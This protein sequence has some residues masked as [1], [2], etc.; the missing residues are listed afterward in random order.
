MNRRTLFSRLPSWVLRLLAPGYSTCLACGVPWRF[1]REHSTPYAHG[2][3]T[4]SGMFPLCEPCWASMK[5]D[6]R[7]PYYAAL[8]AKWD[9]PPDWESVESAVRAGL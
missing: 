2:R 5:P 1:A 3:N 6:E 7:L 4:T 9:S 8:C